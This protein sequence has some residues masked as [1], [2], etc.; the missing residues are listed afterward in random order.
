MNAADPKVVQALR[1]ATLLELFALSTLIDRQMSDPTRIAAARLRLHLGQRVQFLDWRDPPM[2][3]RPA[4]VVALA[5]DHVKVLEEGAPRQWN[6]PHAAVEPAC[7][8]TDG[9]TTARCQAPARRLPRR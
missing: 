5:K 3:M 2:Q 6:L 7:S 1:Q 4:Q 9:T 8:A